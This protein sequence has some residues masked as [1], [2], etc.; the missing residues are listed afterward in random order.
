[1]DISGKKSGKIEGEIHG[2]S[3]KPPE[4][5]T[6]IDTNVDLGLDSKKIDI[7]Q[8]DINIKGPEIK[9]PKGEVNINKDIKI[10]ANL[11]K[12][13]TNINNIHQNN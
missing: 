7:D 11:P 1:M 12:I 8:K 3:I 6:K 10:D 4:I 13:E 5:N 2:K 9:N